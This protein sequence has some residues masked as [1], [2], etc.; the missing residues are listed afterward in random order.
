MDVV[1]ED[2]EFLRFAAESGERTDHLVDVRILY[3][4]IQAKEFLPLV[5]VAKK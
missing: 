4:S 2:V 5:P 1:N 3:C